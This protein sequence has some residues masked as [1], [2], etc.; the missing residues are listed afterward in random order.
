MRLFAMIYDW[1]ALYYKTISKKYECYIILKTLCVV[2]IVAVF[3]A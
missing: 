3:E 2:Q 1:P